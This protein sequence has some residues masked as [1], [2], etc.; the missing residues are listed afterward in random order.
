[1]QAGAS[2]A[3]RRGKE[4]GGEH[5]PPAEPVE[6]GRPPLGQ[7]LQALRHEHRRSC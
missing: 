2:W 1:M 4:G 7:Q 5:G 3:G 6:E